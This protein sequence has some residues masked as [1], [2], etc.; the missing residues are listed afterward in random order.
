MG[1]LCVTFFLRRLYVCSGLV[2]ALIKTRAQN[3]WYGLYE[4]GVLLWSRAFF[5][6]FPSTVSTK[7]LTLAYVQNLTKNTVFFS[8]YETM[9]G[10][11]PPKSVLMQL[12]YGAA[13]GCVTTFFTL[14]LQGILLPPAF[15]FFLSFLFFFCALWCSQ[16]FAC[17]LS[18]PR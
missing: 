18:R 1:S 17:K 16:V 14:P 4:G 6:F 9:K 11:A 7:G 13:A 2:D 10:L 3:G 15:L 8:L 12:S 5:I